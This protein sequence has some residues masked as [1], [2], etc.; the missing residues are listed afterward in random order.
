VILPFES[1]WAANGH[2][3]RRPGTKGIPESTAHSL[4]TMTL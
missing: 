4:K 2:E 1:Q 3:C